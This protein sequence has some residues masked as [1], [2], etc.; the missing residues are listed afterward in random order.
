MDNFFNDEKF[1]IIIVYVFKL[2][3]INNNL[4][5]LKFVISIY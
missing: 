5:S 2:L 1:D 3:L 4:F